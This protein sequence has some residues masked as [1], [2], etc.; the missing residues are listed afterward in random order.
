MKVLLTHGYFLEEDV[1]EQEIMRPYPP[2]GL[3]YISAYLEKNGFPCRVFD[4]TFASFGRLKACLENEQPDLIGIYVNL[5]TK[6]NVLR[7]MEFIRKHPR[8]NDKKIVLGGPE[9]RSHAREFLSRGADIVVLGEGEETMLELLGHFSSAAPKPL[10]AIT[11]ISYRTPGGEW[12]TT[13]ER[14]LIS[15]V[16]SL[17]LPDREKIDLPRYFH[18][19]KARH[20]YSSLSVSTM[21]GCP[22]TCKWCSRSVYGLSYR[23]RDPAHV[24]DEL[25]ELMREYQ[26]DMFWFVDDV[27]TISHKWLKDFAS[28]LNARRLRIRYECITR[29]DRMNAE[30]VRLL[31]ESG[32]HRVWIGAE[33]GSQKVLDA[34]DRRVKAGQVREMIAL[35]KRH[36]IESGTFIM[37]GYPGETQAD[38]ETTI[39][40]LK[41]SR[42]DM[43]TI[44]LAYPI[45]GTAFYQEVEDRFLDR[46]DWDKSTDRD[47][48]FKR[49]YTRKYYDHAVRLVYNEVEF[50]RSGKLKHKLKAL[51]SRGGMLLERMRA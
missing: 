47:I 5:M 36:G 6:L 49:T 23:R 51:L 42:P 28:E 21:R 10:S 26:P 39:A 45:K 29:A 38:I 40:H 33:S 13:P 19:W 34:M 41:L 11:G 25:Q 37:L 7:I 8:L 32:C 44:T 22:Y 12:V 30:V 9:V 50:S 2:L 48:D 35:S 27:F 14:A 31:K 17:P 24:A 16:S 20:G 46:L 18:A 4:S 3:L 15:A 43:Y 1:K